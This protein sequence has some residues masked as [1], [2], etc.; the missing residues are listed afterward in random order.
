MW[1]LN[2]FVT[3]SLLLGLALV[4][5]PIVLHLVM[6]QKPKR[7]VFPALQFVRQRR[8]VNRRR[9]Q[10]R[11]LL[12]LLLR[13]LAV[14]AVL[15]ALAR[16]KVPSLLVGNVMLL[17]V[18]GVIAALVTLLAVVAVFEKKPAWLSGGLGALAAV[19]LLALLLFGW[20]TYHA[21]AENPIG[22]QSEP[23][24]A[25][26]VF[27]TSPRMSYRHQNQTR[28]EQAQQI[29]DW[30]L[31]HLPGG[32]KIAVLDSAIAE[33][34]FSQDE[35]A[36][37][38]AVHR[39]QMTYV[40]TPLTEVVDEAVRTVL[41]DDELRR[42][43]YVFTD[44]TSPAWEG[45]G[46]LLRRRLAEHPEISIYLIDVGVEKPRN[47][48]LGEID[49][50]SGAVL[51]RNATLEI[52][53]TVEA[54]GGAADRTVDLYL[55]KPDPT[56]PLLVDDQ[57]KLPQATRRAQKIL[58]VEPDAPTTVRFRIAAPEEGVHQGQLRMTG[59]DDG[60][61]FDDT[62]YFTVEVESA[63]PVLVV[64]PAGVAP[65]NLVEAIAPRAYVLG[66]VQR[67]QCTEIA[68]NDLGNSRLDDYR[69][70][71]LLD[72]EPMTPD[73]WKRLADYVEGGGGL[74][75]FLGHN[76]RDAESFNS[77]AAQQL[78]PGR[79]TRQFRSP[80]GDLYLSPRSL[81]HPVLAEF[82]PIASRVPWNEFPVY[83]H[84][85]IEPRESARTVLTYA[86]NEPAILESTLGAGR[87]LTMTTPIT[88][89]ARPAGRSAWNELT[90]GDAWPY[91]VLVNEMT[92]YLVGTGEA[93]LNYLVGETAVLPNQ[94]GRDPQRYQLWPPGRD[95][96]PLAAVE[97]RIIFRGLTTPGAY[98]LKGVTV[99]GPV[100]RGFSANTS[101]VASDLRRAD[102]ERLDA[103]LGKDRYELA[104]DVKEID[105]STRQGRQGWEF[106]PFLLVLL[107]LVLGLEQLL[108]NRFYR[109][110]EE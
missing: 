61:A 82:R 71:C 12:L 10:F 75:I 63:W 16:P 68:Q 105:L 67:Y 41:T 25:V 83:L 70:V 56:L 106:Y 13:C 53:T 5:V 22:D 100:V 91:F 14:I 110:Q 101:R 107:V 50:A 20:R 26:L 7:L 109:K 49:L 87:V 48:A 23:I 43:V 73:A 9:L 99:D 47:A 76:A 38:E 42:E 54:V 1:W 30:V 39:L 97:G 90:L 11:H 89:P 24:A 78:L 6:R 88:E 93:R 52:E 33:G 36:A 66:G 29:A 69:A 55:E 35:A 8:E 28:L 102:A 51:A 2:W 108:A 92:D 45:K 60:L 3:P 44:K 57:L 96:Q 84:W 98:R 62:R 74:A 94:F 65:T 21:G 64:S 103:V 4:A 86:N 19:L 72:P 95:L 59:G 46:E 77:T 15:A 81:E 80:V 85:Q 18:G 27:D 17:V 104:R 58:R 37:R 40:P 32:S 79:L 31:D 34:V